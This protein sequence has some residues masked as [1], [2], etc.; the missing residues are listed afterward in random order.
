MRKKIIVISSIVLLFF[1]GMIAITYGDDGFVPP[2][3]PNPTPPKNNE[4]KRINRRAEKSKNIAVLETEDFSE[5]GTPS[6][7]VPEWVKPARWFRSN[8]GG[9]ALKEIPSRYAAL[10]S[11]YA[12]VI[13]FAD[14]EELPDILARYYQ[15]DFFIEVRRL[16]KNSEESRVQWIFRDINGTAR[17]ISVLFEHEAALE[18]EDADEAAVDDADDVEN[19]DIAE[20]TERDTVEIY[21]ASLEIAGDNEEEIIQEISDNSENEDGI[22]GG[23]IEI[24]NE[25]AILETEFRFSDNGGR[26]RTDYEY[27]NGFLVSS[28][29]FVLEKNGEGEEYVESYADYFRYN[30]SSFL[31]SI[32]RVFYKERQVL[33]DEIAKVSFPSNVLAA[34]RNEYFMNAKLN[35][36]PEFF[37]DLSVKE[38]YRLVTNTDDRGRII[39][40]ILYDDSKE[41]KIIWVIKN[42]WSGD[43][44][45]STVKTE[46]ETEYLAEYEFNSKGD[47]ILERN[48]KDGVLERLVRT[49]EKTDIEELYLN[50]VVVLQTVWEDGRKIS[51]TRIRN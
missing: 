26:Y 51:E 34:A 9:M 11:E 5:D 18:T 17:L 46:G 10:R 3:L 25:D 39:S 43:R 28:H 8:A 45:V 12:L 16:Y 4:N 22:R 50:N 41:E 42:T 32:E 14:A 15:K 38:N 1:A 31:R 36:Y 35:S 13:D 7:P 33:L 20:E 48:I 6:P 44:I 2:P 37:G 24:F 21:N 29:V 27:N 30:R 19:V 47:R 40:Q 23:F 49:E